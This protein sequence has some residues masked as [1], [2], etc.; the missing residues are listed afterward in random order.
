MSEDHP[1]WLAALIDEGLPEPIMSIVDNAGHVGLILDAHGVFE[2]AARMNPP[3]LIEARFATSTM[4]ESCWRGQIA[5]HYIEVRTDPMTYHECPQP[6]NTWRALNTD[7][8]SFVRS[9]VGDGV[10]S[11]LDRNGYDIVWRAAAT[12]DRPYIDSAVPLRV[13]EDA[14]NRKALVADEGTPAVRCEE[15]NPVGPGPIPLPG[16]TYVGRPVEEDG[17]PVSG[18]TTDVDEG[19]HLFRRSGARDGGSD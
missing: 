14:A 18:G 19:G 9:M 16:G 15:A 7:H 8:L 1:P 6:H 17:L 4:I 11:L 13:T 3:R 10:V 12:R 5:G 2:W